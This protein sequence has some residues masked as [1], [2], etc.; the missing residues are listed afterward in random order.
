MWLA[1]SR[2]FALTE[3]KTRELFHIGFLIGIKVIAL[4]DAQ[5]LRHLSFRFDVAAYASQY[6]PEDIRALD[7]TQFRWLCRRFTQLRS[8]A[9]QGLYLEDKLKDEFSTIA[10]DELRD[11]KGLVL[12]GEPGAFFRC[13]DGCCAWYSGGRLNSAITL[14][15]DVLLEY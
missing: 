10:Q 5:R 9:L 11:L 3:E 8:F 14:T 13:D 7:W 1:H 4:L 15:H 2:G 12:Y 6:R